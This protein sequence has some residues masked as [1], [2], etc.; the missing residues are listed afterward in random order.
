M[1]LENYEAALSRDSD[2]ANLYKNETKNSSAFYLRRGIVNG[3][4][5]IEIFAWENSV[6]FWSEN[7]L[8]LVIFS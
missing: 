4:I 3:Q 7:A 5:F 2:T 8:N 1:Q 6:R